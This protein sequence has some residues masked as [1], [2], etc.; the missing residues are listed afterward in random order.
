[1]EDEVPMSFRD[2]MEIGLDPD[3]GFRRDNLPK[4]ERKTQS[5]TAEVADA[6]G[7]ARHHNEPKLIPEPIRA[8]IRKPAKKPAKVAGTAKKVRSRPPASKLKRRF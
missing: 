4:R 1:M 8:R 2:K 5:Q 7:E 6:V 3:A